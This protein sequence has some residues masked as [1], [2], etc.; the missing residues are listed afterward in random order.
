MP[1][2]PNPAR[3]ALYWAPP[4]TDSLAAAGASW[5]GYD[6]ETGAAV[7]QPDMSGL[8]DATAAPAGYGFH[9]TLS[10]PMRLATGWTEFITAAAELT[11]RTPP[12][13][14]PPLILDSLDGFLALREATPC[15]AL[16]AL[17][18]AC[19]RAAHPHRLRP[20]D[21]E[22]A[23]RRTGLSAAEDML[24]LRWGYPYVLDRWRFHMTLTRRLA[25]A[26]ADILRPLA[27]RHFSAAISRPRSVG[28]LTVFTQAHAGAAFRIAERL[29]F[30]AK[31]SLLF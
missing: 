22:L 29:S 2:T 25:P 16:A 31:T 5:L 21:A 14:L 8:Q 27:D 7:T 30:T 18:E 4:A 20:D 13:A 17:A 23:R 3:V 9:A 1:V 26:E 11:A 6:A 24:L 12:F 15:P 10:P 19:L 28:A